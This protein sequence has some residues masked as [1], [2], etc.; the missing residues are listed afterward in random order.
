M[1]E[2]NLRKDFTRAERQ[3]NGRKGAAVTNAKKIKRKQLKEILDVFLK[4][5][6]PQKMK[7]KALEILPDLENE[8]LSL[9]DTLVVCL[10]EKIIAGDTKAF[11]IMRD[12]IGE[13]PVE[14]IGTFEIKPPVIN[15]D[16]G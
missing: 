2:K 15:D 1:N 10:I 9:K 4:M 7:D 3:E 6:A 12:T 14:K 11:E 5:E 8:R 16:I 13:K